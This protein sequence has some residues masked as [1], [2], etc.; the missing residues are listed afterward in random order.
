MKFGSHSLS[1]QPSPSSRTG[2]DTARQSPPASRL[3]FGAQ[4]PGVAAVAVLWPQVD[5]PLQLLVWWAALALTW[6]LVHSLTRPLHRRRPEDVPL[7]H[8]LSTAGALVSGTAWG[9]LALVGPYHAS[10]AAQAIL[11]IV[12]CSVALAGSGLIRRSRITC[13]TF[14]AATLL[15][16]FILSVVSPPAAV[17]AAG[18]WLLAFAFFIIAGAC[19]QPDSAPAPAPAA[20][21]AAPRAHAH[22]L[23]KAN[24]AILLSR[25]HRI[26][27]CNRR[28]AEMMRSDEHDIAGARLAAGFESRADWRRHARAAGGMI[29]RGGTYHSSARLR[30]RDGSVF[31]AELTGQAVDP[32]LSPLQVVWVA[33]DMTD[34]M[35]AAAREERHAAQLRSLIGRSTDW[36][37]QTDAQHRL[38]HVVH[39]AGGTDDT[40]K[41]KLG[42]KWWQ[43]R[44]AGYDPRVETSALRSAF[45]NRHG[46]R[47]L[48]VELPDGSRPPLWLNICGVPRVDEHGA[49]LGHHGIAT[50][51]TEQVR[52]TERVHHLAYHDALTGLPNR[53]LLS[54][55][56][57]HAIALARRNRQQIGVIVVDLD[58]FRRINEL[59]GHGAGDQALLEAADRLRGCVRA[60]DTVARFGSDEFVV[61]L[62]DVD[63]AA[64]AARVAAKIQSALHAPLS[65]GVWPHPLC[66][67]I[68]VATFP[69]DAADAA[70]LINVADG[71]MFRAKRRGGQRIE[72]H[73]SQPA[74]AVDASDP[75]YP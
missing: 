27:I 42:R 5:Q 7:H 44:P 21:D 58:D 66:T 74:A 30:R 56:L 46:F 4:L 24:T 47:D 39:H 57:N 71:R 12:L 38:M 1:R 65:C 72:S 59:G 55:R 17:P 20:P 51:I 10:P 25:G 19:L 26:E 23:E 75:L 29:G 62:G 3:Q 69:I 22:M 35:N 9:S 50:D 73:G 70:G 63:N 53:R 37:W 28:F 11:F 67:S 31:W 34:T 32:A 64:A 13:I 18:L 33:F 15:P 61:L 54:D 14:V 8:Y 40:L 16:L 41:R 60:C 45:E 48:R 36:Y 43:F 52:S 6:I 2:E 49:F 68:G